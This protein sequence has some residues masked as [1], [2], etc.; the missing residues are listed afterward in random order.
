MARS[1]TQIIYA[2][3][4]KDILRDRRTVLSAVLFP[5]VIMPVLMLV[6]GG[7]TA[8]QISAL[9]AKPSSIG[10][11]GRSDAAGAKLKLT[12]QGSVNLLDALEDTTAA[13]GMLRDKDLDA[14]VLVPDG[15]DEALGVVMDGREGRVPNIIIYS[16]QTNEKSDFAA[17]KV[18]QA[19]EEARMEQVEGALSS[20]GLRPELI[21]PFQIERQN[22]VS[23]EG[24]SKSNA[25]KIIPYLV[26]VMILV[27]ATYPAIDLT[28]GE[29]ERGTLET[30]LVAG[31]SRM[32]IVMGKFLT[33][34]T[35]SMVTAALSL[36]S[37][38][39]TFSNAAILSPKMAQ[40]FNFGLDLQAALLLGLTLVPLGVIF[41]AGLM[42]LSLF[43]KSY[44][45][46]QTYVSPLMIL[47][48]FPAMVSMLPGVEINAWMA[49]VPILNVSLL[50]KQ[51]LV[52]RIEL[53]PLLLTMASN[54]IAA[55]AMLALFF[56]MF[57]R[58]TVLF[59][60]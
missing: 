4:V 51:A 37:L 41:S 5:I 54:I 44:R 47:V 60:T 25:A 2:K 35:V 58:E 11:I 6:V 34:F 49:I 33:V 39:V 32:A 17:A 42:A 15:F 13:L 21:K 46:A 31:V 12:T 45:E 19:A 52:G 55:A 48:I 59:R 1:G 50:L 23:A 29:K 10:W 28:A 14:V 16:D 3:E 24:M 53:V 57:R 20:R 40:A 7:L 9:K 43:A 8:R 27:G 36:T 38:A 56:R 30:L 22:I 26:I 18:M